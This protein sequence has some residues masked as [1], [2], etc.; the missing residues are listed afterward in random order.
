M[1]LQDLTTFRLILNYSYLYEAEQYGVDTIQYYYKE[2]NETFSLPIKIK[3]GTEDQCDF[4]RG[5][6]P[7][8]RY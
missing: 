6:A 3:A 7:E 5:R 4:S 8:C 1:R 2:K